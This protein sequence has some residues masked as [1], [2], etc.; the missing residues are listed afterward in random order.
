ML[1]GI[2]CAA[3][4][5]GHPAI[6]QVPNDGHTSTDPF[7]SKRQKEDDNYGVDD[8]AADVGLHQPPVVNHARRRAVT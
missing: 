3:R 5:R 1:L 8:R 6:D 7:N 2:G 4:G